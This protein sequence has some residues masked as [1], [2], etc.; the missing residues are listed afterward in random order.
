MWFSAVI[1][2]FCRVCSCHAPFW[3]SNA[4]YLRLS[5]QPVSEDPHA[6]KTPLV[7]SALLLA[8]VPNLQRQ[9]TL[10]V[11]VKKNKSSFEEQLH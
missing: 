5:A 7:Q 8:S 11:G 6:R 4:V 3:E 1:A 9:E 2:R 10:V